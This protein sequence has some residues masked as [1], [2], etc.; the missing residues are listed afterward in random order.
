[1][2][3]RKVI[4]LTCNWE[5]HFAPPSLKAYLIYQAAQPAISFEGGFNVEMEMRIVHKWS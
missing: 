1:M 3:L 2:L 4:I 5:E